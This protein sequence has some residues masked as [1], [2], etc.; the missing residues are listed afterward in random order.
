[1][2]LEESLSISRER[3]D[4]TA[5]GQVLQ[6][7][8]AACMGQGDLAAARGYLTEALEI[9]RAQA[10]SRNV[11]AAI[12]ALAQLH[13]LEGDIAGAEPLYEEVLARAREARDRESIAIALLNLAMTS[14]HKEVSSRARGL[15][16][17]AVQIAADTGSKPVGQSVLEV[18]SGLAAV[19]RAWECAARFYGAAEAEAARTGLRRDPADEAFLAPRIAK[20]RASAGE[21]A[22]AAVEATGRQLPYDQALAAARAWLVPSG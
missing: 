5:M 3:G 15:L 16:A 6:P 22:F 20:A 14:I 21:D 18:T 8:G 1:M 12:N 11:L 4:R 13:H 7:L 17:E 2:Q 9:A 10:D 19:E